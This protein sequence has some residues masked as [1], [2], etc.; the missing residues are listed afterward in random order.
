MA[1]EVVQQVVLD[2]LLEPRAK[3]QCRHFNLGTIGTRSGLEICP[4]DLDWNLAV[5]EHTV[6]PE[7]GP[8]PRF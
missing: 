2:A 6:K 8:A 4:R 3:N 1:V 5:I 7:V